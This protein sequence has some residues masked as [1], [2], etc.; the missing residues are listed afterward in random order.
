MKQLILALA[1]TVSLVFE[2]YAP[3]GLSPFVKTAHADGAV[4]AEEFVSLDD[5]NLLEYVTDSVYDE[6]VKQLADGNHFVENVSAVYLSQEYLDEVA[7]NSESNVFFGYTLEELEQQFQGASY[8][9]TLGDDGATDVQP[10]EP[11]DDTV[12]QVIKN[13]AIGTGVILLCVT[14]SV[15]TAGVGAPAAVSAVFAV[16]AKTATAVAVSSA[17]IGGAASGIVTGIETGDTE[18]ALKA[19]ALSASEEFKW[20]AVAGAVTGGVAETASLAGAARAGLT[21]SEAAIIQK[22]AGWPLS[23]IKTLHSRKEFEIYK[24]AG[25]QPMKVNGKWALT[26]KINWKATDAK[27]RTN[28]E[29]VEGGQPPVD[30]NGVAYELHHIGQLADAPFAVLTKTEHIS[31]GNKNILHWQ[32]KDWKTQYDESEFAKQRKE[33][34]QAVLSIDLQAGRI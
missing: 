33:F 9:F 16:S 34:W 21:L 15:V 23:V 6:L 4:T 31:G 17:A 5:P 1:L 3:A 27:G 10:F 8:V 13:V 25:L 26:R 29:R 19:A 24:A 20:G 32:G 30:E 12:E 28:V 11:Y 7:F 18:Q 14:V 2:G 22:E